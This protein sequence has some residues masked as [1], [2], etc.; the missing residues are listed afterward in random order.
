[1]PETTA[2]PTTTPRSRLRASC[3]AMLAPVLLA[4]CVG[5]PADVDAVRRELAAQMA[6]ERSVRCRE[7]LDLPYPS[8]ADPGF[9]G[10]DAR[11][12]RW[13]A[14]E[15]RPAR[16]LTGLVEPSGGARTRGEFAG[17]VGF[18]APA[19]D[20]FAVL[21]E[22]DFAVDLVGVDPARRIDPVLSTTVR[23][24]GGHVRAVFFEMER[25]RRY[26]VQLRGSDERVVRFALQ[27]LY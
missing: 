25:G 16:E 19:A 1:M 2:A 5:A 3:V 22:K 12:N 8:L 21:V 6:V 9:A 10:A 27:R 14:L 4:A 20:N 7:G 17:F 23:A 15:L 26:A 24:C 18:V 13:L 11:F